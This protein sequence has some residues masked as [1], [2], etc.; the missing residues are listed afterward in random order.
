MRFRT[1][2]SPFCVHGVWF[3][4]NV[5]GFRLRRAPSL[6]SGQFTTKNRQYSPLSLDK[7]ASRIHHPICNVTN[8]ERDSEADTTWKVVETRHTHRRGA[9]RR[10]DGFS[11]AR[12]Q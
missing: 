6:S 10:L 12:A 4:S 8:R 5:N 1:C 7:P 3:N 11:V 2:V 9:R